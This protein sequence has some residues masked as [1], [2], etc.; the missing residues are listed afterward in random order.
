MISGMGSDTSCRTY[1]SVSGI[2]RKQGP[3]N[4]MALHRL[5]W[6]PTAAQHRAGLHMI[7]WKP[8]IGDPEHFLFV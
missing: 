8:G 6:L 5:K 2:M 1:Q 4:S 7:W 3:G